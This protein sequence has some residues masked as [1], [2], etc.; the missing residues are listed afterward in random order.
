MSKCKQRYRSKKIYFLCHT[1]YFTKEIFHY[2]G[3]KIHRQLPSMITQRGTHPQ[4]QNLRKKYCVQNDLLKGRYNDFS[5]I[6]TSCYYIKYYLSMQLGLLILTKYIVFTVSKSP[7]PNVLG[8]LTNTTNSKLFIDNKTL[9]T[10][11]T[12]AFPDNF[13]LFITNKSEIT[14]QRVLQ[15]LPSSF[16][17]ISSNQNN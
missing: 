9:C 13:F 14:F 16:V 1:K 7:F 6:N 5:A 15:N 3:W 8:S 4:Y 10:K 17:Y 11:Y 2:R 12:E